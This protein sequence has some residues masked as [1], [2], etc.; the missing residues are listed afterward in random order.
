M[1]VP[2]RYSHKTRSYDHPDTST[3]YT[4]RMPDRVKKKV[5]YKMKHVE[6]INIY[7]EGAACT[8]LSHIMGMSMFSQHYTSSG[9]I[10]NEINN[11]F[12]VAMEHIKD[13]HMH[14]LVFRGLR[15]ST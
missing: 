5:Q 11:G 6:V 4:E 7:T 15:H 9:N 2:A 14:Q 8:L 10:V 13:M 12:K 3:S 1:V